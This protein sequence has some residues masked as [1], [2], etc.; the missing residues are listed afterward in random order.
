MLAAYPLVRNLSALS[1]RRGVFTS[2]SREGSSPNSI[3]MRWI[4]SCIVLLYVAAATA[5]SGATGVMPLL[6]AATG[7]QV[8]T[9]DPD[10]LYKD[11]ENLAS[12]KQAAEIWT[13]RLAAN[14]KD[15][16]AA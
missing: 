8:P 6:D 15:F 5:A 9:D 4:R 11:R 14:P 1:T 12:A 10:A 13:A 3:S 7:V 2:P 16:N